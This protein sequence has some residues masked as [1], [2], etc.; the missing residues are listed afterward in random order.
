MEN[1]KPPTSMNNITKTGMMCLA[2]GILAGA[3]GCKSSSE[4]GGAESGSA[5]RSL[6][7]PYYDGGYN[8]TPG[9]AT[10]V[11]SY[12][13]SAKITNSATGTI[14]FTPPSGTTNGTATDLSGLSAPYSSVV[15]AMRKR[16]MMAWCGSNT[17]TFPASS[18]DQ[19]KFTIYI[20]NM[21]P[22]PTNGQI[23]TLDV[24]WD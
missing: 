3:V 12:S 24:Q 13:G 9:S 5:E 18:T 23:L 15:L 2:A 8:G 10:C 21:P 7:N 17:V 1:L 6:I 11:G 4:K 19:Y 16:D 14:W 22:P 20:K